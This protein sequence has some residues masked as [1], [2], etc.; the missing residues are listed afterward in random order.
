MLMGVMVKDGQDGK[1]ERVTLCLSVEV[2][3]YIASHSWCG[4]NVDERKKVMLTQR[5]SKDRPVR[6]K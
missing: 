5:R 1:K 3:V 2:A 6:K 4:V